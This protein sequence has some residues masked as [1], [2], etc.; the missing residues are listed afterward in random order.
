MEKLR[1]EVYELVVMRGYTQSEAGEKLGISRRTVIR[2]LKYWEEHPEE[3][4]TPDDIRFLGW[5]QHQFVRIIEEG[6]LT[7]YQKARLLKD[8][9]RAGLIRR[10]MKA[11]AV[12]IRW[13]EYEGDTDQEQE[14]RPVIRASQVSS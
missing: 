13:G 4:P 3:L 6:E 11:E 9:I 10:I 7:D 5:S 2:Y 1:R 8:I 14:V 12:S